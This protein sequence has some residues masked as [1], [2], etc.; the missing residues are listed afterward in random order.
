MIK[1]VISDSTG[2][3]IIAIILGVGLAAIFRRSC[4]GD[5]CVVVTSPGHDEI[6]NN[7]YKL[8][9][10]CYKYTPYAVDCESDEK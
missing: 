10:N 5:K 2:S 6:R 7:F 1:D 8:G 9:E 4:R 3:K